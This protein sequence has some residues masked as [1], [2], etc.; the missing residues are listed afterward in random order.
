M[1]TAQKRTKREKNPDTPEVTSKYYLTNAKLL[2]AVL[3]AKETGKLTDELAGMLLLLSQKY[4]QHPNFSGYTY[5]EDM[6]ADAMANLCVAALKFDPAKS[7]NPF[8]FYTSCITHSFYQFLNVEKRHRRIRDELLIEMGENPSYNFASE[9]KHQTTEGGEYKTELTDMKDQIEEAKVRVK[10]EI[11]RVAAKKAAEEA[12][13]Q[14]EL[15]AA[16][17]LDYD[18]EK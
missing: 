12:E 18:G 6:I 7:N 8:A 17:L 5:K 1:S 10:Q 11:E 3:R 15:E 14:R 13:K 4:A 2:P 9:Y 16:S